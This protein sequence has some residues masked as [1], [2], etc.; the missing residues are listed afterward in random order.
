MK[1]INHKASFE[2]EIIERIEAGLA[3]H[4]NEVKSLRDKRAKLEGAF[5]K[6]IGGEAVLVNAEIYPYQFDS[7]QTYDSKRTRKLLLHKREIVKLES[8]LKGGALTLIP[9]SWYTMG[10]NWKLE[11]GLCR[12]KKQYEKREKIKKEDVR[13]EVSR[14]FRG[15]IK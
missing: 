12:G 9:L 3:L 1:L 15:K 4:G 5:V 7:N 2:Y 11:I 13:R 10:H 8:K 6:I 14:T